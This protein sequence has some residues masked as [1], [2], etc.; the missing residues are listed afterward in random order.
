MVHVIPALDLIIFFFHS[1]YL[2]REH[3]LTV[4]WGSFDFFF[5]D[6]KLQSK[7][8]ALI[9]S[10]NEIRSIESLVLDKFKF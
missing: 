9:H 8:N 10:S 6:F 4:D 7:L 2:S 5:A 1:P 3:W